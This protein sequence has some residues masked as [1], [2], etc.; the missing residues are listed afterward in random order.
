MSDMSTNRRHRRRGRAAVSALAIAVLVLVGNVN[1]AHAEDAVATPS[2][3]LPA[4]SAAPT[5]SAPLPTAP[6]ATKPA[7]APKAPATTSAVEPKSVKRAT[8]TIERKAIATQTAGFSL[9]YAFE[10]GMYPSNPQLSYDGSPGAGP[11]EKASNWADGDVRYLQWDYP[12]TQNGGHTVVFTAQLIDTGKAT[13]YAVKYT[14]RVNRSSGSIAV[15]TDCAILY[16]GSAID[17]G[18]QS[19]YNCS[20]GKAQGASGMVLATTQTSLQSWAGIT[21]NIQVSN[22]DDSAPKISLANGVFGTTN[23]FHRII[24]NGST[25]Y[26]FDDDGVAQPAP[27]YATISNGESLTWSASALNLPHKQAEVSSHAQ[28]YFIYEILLGGESTGYWLKG[29]GDN[30]KWY[31][32]WYPTAKCE[33]YAGNPNNGQAPIT[34][35]TPFTCVPSEKEGRN[36]KDIGSGTMISWDAPST[37][38]FVVQMAPVDT[39]HTQTD[40]QDRK[41]R[42]AC[43]V[44]DGACVITP[45]KKT[46]PPEVTSVPQTSKGSAVMSNDSGGE[47][48]FAFDFTFSREVKNT[49][50]QMF[51]VTTKVKVGGSF[52]GSKS[53]TSIEFTSE[54]T[55]GYDISNG[56]E[57]AQKVSERLPFWS[58][59]SFYYTD[60]FDVY[61][62]DVYFFGESDIWYRATGATITVPVP[63][64][65]PTASATGGPLVEPDPAGGNIPGLVYQCIWMEQRVDKIISKVID[66]FDTAHQIRPQDR[67]T[68]SY[69]ESLNACNIPASWSRLEETA[70]SG[71]ER[72]LKWQVLQELLGTLTVH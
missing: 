39:L 11:A 53:E 49:L 30:Y 36:Y 14:S 43:G 15:S 33:I 66:D 72:H 21:G 9:R 40:A 8:P 23:Q 32:W 64:K 58:T 1:A 46:R 28:A 25:W 17:L 52:M 12:M 10:P 44:D 48:D 7:P 16:K 37:T 31:S 6:A 41:V 70:F 54:T 67:K 22:V 56:F 27:Q 60:V 68:S 59:A 24:M 29:S 34:H 35:A 38:N 26:P 62:T 45:G 63:S 55:F 2:P 3:S 5:D 13:D 19:P 20:G 65:V 42:D 61:S 50:E 51:G 57:V 18:S 4:T 47:G 69:A 71:T